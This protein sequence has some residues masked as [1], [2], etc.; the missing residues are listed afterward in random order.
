MDPR[1]LQY[2]NLELQHLREMG[3][4]FAEQFPKIAGRLG[5][6]GIEVA[7][8]YVERL[9]E[10]AAFLAARVQLKLDAEFPRFTQA[11]L[12]LVHPHY[13]APVPSMLV[14]QMRPAP[15]DK[16]LADGSKQVPR[17]STLQATLGEG[18]S[19]ACE[20]V[21][22]QD[23][24]LWPLEV[25]S[26]SYFS[27]APD[28]PLNAL[29]VGPRIRGGVR[30]RLKTTAEM[31]FGQL[32][33]DRLS[34]YA[35]GAD[36]VANRLYELC[37][38][39]P[40]GALVRPVG[41][42]QTWHE[43]LPATAI[44]PRGFTDADALLPASHR[45]FH[46]YRILQEYFAFPERFRFFDVAGLRRA[47]SRGT[48]EEL[49]LV[50]LF[51]RGDPTL[52]RVV[53]ASNLKLFCT[54]AIN[55]FEKHADR[56][57]VDD[58]SHEHHVLPDRANPMDYEVYD[59]LDVRG[60]GAGSALEQEFV[61][62]YASNSRHFTPPTGYFTL[63]REPRLV[64]STQRRRGPRSSYIGSE[65]FLSLVDGAQAPY[66]GGLRQLS[67]R[68]RCSNRDLVLLM[69]IGSGKTDFLLDVAA[70]VTSVRV[71]AGPSRPF[72]PLADGAAAWRAIDH[73]ALNYLSL[74]DT[75]PDEGAAALRDLLQLYAQASDPGTR[76]QVDGVRSTS[77]NRVVRRLPGPGPL[78]FGRGLEIAVTVDE[79][80][81]EGGSAFLLGSV[82]N[83]YLARHVSMNTFIETV[84]RSQTRGEI[85]RWVPRWGAK[86]TL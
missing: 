25:A 39:A 2:Y 66:A 76:K 32:A 60:H 42:T 21:T 48:T 50:L 9:L 36:D 10:G 55:L 56:I 67:L 29:N 35:G 24:T 28:L 41:G 84:L 53:D 31:K 79:L 46:G 64:S 23:V 13:L 81:F 77:V 85:N 3:A 68:V 74:V 34:F 12:E 30:I 11:L 83:E 49:E 69:P 72:A 7:D 27:Y 5:M 14:A 37:L 18:E 58:G 22:A 70:P 75:T 15:D 52:E 51:E 20:F 59:V 82:L 33:L 45:T 80:A 65:V 54:P 4:E 19:T 43:F 47:V 16:N 40:L 26:A 86:P 73:L 62:F 78:T 44:A 71:V 57:N 8:P 1:L 61:P 38:A 63:R 6:Q 17:G